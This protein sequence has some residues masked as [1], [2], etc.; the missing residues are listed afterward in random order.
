MAVVVQYIRYW[1]SEAFIW[2]GFM[3]QAV[4]LAYRLLYTNNVDFSLR[5]TT[6][7]TQLQCILNADGAMFL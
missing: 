5:L 2:Y 4:L 1:H 7:V 3:Q 6:R